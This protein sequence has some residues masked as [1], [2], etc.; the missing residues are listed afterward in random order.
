M[1]VEDIPQFMFDGIDL[2]M[3]SKKIT[4][5]RYLCMEGDQN[6]AR[7]IIVHDQIVNTKDFAVG[8]DDVVDLGDKFLIRSLAQKGAYGI[9]QI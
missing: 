8:G 3:Q 4:F 1:A 9:L 7:T 2:I 5:R 6:P